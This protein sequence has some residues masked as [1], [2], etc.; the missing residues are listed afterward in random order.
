MGLRY[1]RI[2]R[3]VKTVLAIYRKEKRKETTLSGPPSR[4]G[5]ASVTFV[6]LMLAFLW[7]A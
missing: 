3:T 6:R 2:Q 7:K 5:N 4:T 1:M